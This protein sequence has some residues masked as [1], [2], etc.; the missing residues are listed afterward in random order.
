MRQT[1]SS[2]STDDP[3]TGLE[4]LALGALYVAFI[5]IAEMSLSCKL[6]VTYA[7][8]KEKDQ[9]LT[10]AS[11]KML[12]LTEI[13]KFITILVLGCQWKAIGSIWEI[14]PHASLPFW[15]QR[16]I[17]GNQTAVNTALQLAT[18]DKAK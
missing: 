18:P 9:W 10:T 16:G 8:R 11:I 17:I 14:T 12:S 5:K 2:D 4:R 6:C 13:M 15:K 7:N 1:G 3:V